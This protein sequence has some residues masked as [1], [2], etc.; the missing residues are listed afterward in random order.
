MRSGLIAIYIFLSY[1]LPGHLTAGPVESI[2]AQKVGVTFFKS[3][4]KKTSE[5]KLQF[6]TVEKDTN[7]LKSAKAIQN[8]FY[9]IISNKDDSSFVIVSGYDNVM[10]ILGYSEKGYINPEGM[11]DNFNEW[12]QWRASEIQYA[13]DNNLQA[14]EEVKAKWDELL[15]DLKNTGIIIVSPLTKTK[16]N[17][18]KYFNEL[19]PVDSGSTTKNYKVWG[20]CGAIA[21]AQIMKYWNYPVSGKGSKSYSTKY[22]VLSANFANTTFQWS[23]MPN[24]LTTTNGTVD[25]LIYFCGIGVEMNYGPTSSLSYLWNGNSPS[26]KYALTNYFKY[27]TKT[28]KGVSRSSYLDNAWINLIKQELNNAKPVIYQGGDKTST[29]SHFFICDGYDSNNYFHINWGWGGSADGYFT[30]NKLLPYPTDTIKYNFSYNHYALIGIEPDSTKTMALSGLNK[31]LSIYPNPN[32]GT[33][34]ISNI[35]STDDVT[36]KLIDVNGKIVYQTRR[37]A[38]DLKIEIILPRGMYYL[39]VTNKHVNKLSKLLITN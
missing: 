19:C 32:S 33:F 39:V 6:V 7:R 20:G 28:I 25:S 21:M 35:G 26:I 38:T 29:Y 17:Q 30:L 12:I 31:E 1:C 13:A 27:N 11:P 14:S 36:V 22:G 16:W 23:K 18:G 24:S 10:P 15:N 5:A 34:Y 9:Y 4:S 37:Q 3:V 2:K 8:P